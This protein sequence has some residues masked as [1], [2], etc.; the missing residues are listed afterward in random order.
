M[1]TKRKRALISGTVQGVAFRAY[2]R[3]TARRTGVSGWVRNLPD[4]RVEAVFEGEANKVEEV[5]LWC[6]KGSPGSRV[7]AVS[8]IEEPPKGESGEFSITY[9]KGDPWW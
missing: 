8:V 5:I 4:G 2:T 1:P 9:V 7:E 6:H 3:E